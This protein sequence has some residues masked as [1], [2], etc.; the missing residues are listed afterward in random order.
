MEIGSVLWLFDEDVTEEKNDYLIFIQ[1]YLFPE[2]AN[3]YFGRP[4]RRLWGL[5]LPNDSA[6][7]RILPMIELC[8]VFVREK[9]SNGQRPSAF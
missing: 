3:P 5:L 6:A 1:K 2:F 7:S 8:S 9:S 4:N